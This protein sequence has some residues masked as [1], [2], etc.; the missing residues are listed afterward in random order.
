MSVCK[1][2]IF[3]LKEINMIFYNSPLEIL[4]AF[5]IVFSLGA[6]FVIGLIVF[7]NK[8]KK[9]FLEKHFA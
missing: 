6:L 5:V 1:F 7:I 8:T 2:I 3:T 4:A 9:V